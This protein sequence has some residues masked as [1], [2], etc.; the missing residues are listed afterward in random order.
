[1]NTTHRTKGKDPRIDALLKDIGSRRSVRGRVF[2]LRDIHIKEHL[3]APTS[4]A[5]VANN[6]IIP[7]LVPPSLGCGMGLVA[8]TL[9]KDDITPER[10]RHFFLR[11]RDDVDFSHAT[12]FQNLLEWLGFRKPRHGRYDWNREE[13]ARIAR[14]GA[15]AILTRYGL[16]DET[17]EHVEYGGEVPHV[18][19]LL[20]SYPLK[21]LI[22]RAGWV[23][24]RRNIG[25]GFGGN[26]FIE[27]QYVDEIA[28]ADTARAWGLS[29]NQLV[30]LYHGGEGSLAYY[31]GRYFS[32]RRKFSFKENLMR[33][34]AK[35][36]FHIGEGHPLRI[37]RRVWRASIRVLFDE[38]SL[39]EPDGMRQ[40]LA[41]CVSQNYSYA[42]RMGMLARIRDSLRA[43]FPEKSPDVRLVWD[44]SH[45]SVVPKQEPPG[46]DV[47]HQ[48]GAARIH[49][50]KPVIISGAA[51]T[52][53]FLGRGK[54]DGWTDHGA[55]SVIQ[56]HAKT[57]TAD[58]RG[59]RT[60]VFSRTLEATPMP[61]MSDA[62]LSEVTYPLEQNGSIAPVAFLRPI[63][64]Y[65]D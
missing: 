45:V 36:L 43:V 5:A 31:I 29:H 14:E 61:H 27:I 4:F 46:T 39:L 13:L 15:G 17:R 55:G 59:F 44:T 63:A 58:K 23:G 33:F 18:E 21:R 20:A 65:R 57:Q 53:S 25:Y 54:K 56:E 26:H 3:E 40:F 35:V 9:S 28:D 62:G 47:I 64:T 7:T 22:P 37:L 51:T 49:P 30:I 52:R 6:T 11:L 2:P 12:S 60:L 34:P 1:M 50:E 32:N 10:A 38:I 42:Y 41:M 19:H 16:P 8:T 48:S 24:A